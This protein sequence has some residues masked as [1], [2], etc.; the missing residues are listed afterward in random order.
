MEDSTRRKLDKFERQDVFM[1]ESAA[2]FP[3]GSPGDD[4]AVVN[5]NIVTEMNTLAA[6]QISGGSSAAQSFGNK[7]EDLDELLVMLRNMNR[8]A[9]AFEVEVP[10]SNL[11]F[12]MP[13]NRSEQ[14]LLA[15]ARAFQTDAAPLE[16]KFIEYGLADDFLDQLFG[17][18][19]D[20]EQGG[21]QADSGV[22]QRAASTA[23]LLDAARRGMAN[24]RRM[25]AIV[26]IKY[27]NNPQKLAAWTVASHLERAPKKDEPT[28]TPPSPPPAPTP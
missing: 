23:G 26:R 15:T 11:Q 19:N 24:S 6:Q 25:D 8:A 16:A 21:A 28:P 1:V 14:N 13:R 2:D 9:N 5:R 18:I 22:G 4:V 20:I 10:G 27:A 17:K 12:R 7:E 3:A